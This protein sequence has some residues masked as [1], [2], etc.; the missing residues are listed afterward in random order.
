MV[1]FPS[2][3]VLL[4]AATF[5][6]AGLSPAPATPRA[7]QAAGTVVFLGDSLTAGYGLD[8][9]MAFPALVQKEIDERNWPWRVV[10]AGVSGETSAGGLRRID[11]LL[12][13]RIDVLVL[14]LGGN[15]GLR[16]IP[17]ESTRSNLQ[18]IIDRTRSR[19]PNVR[20]VI[21]GM[22][23]PPNL[24][25]TYTSAFRD[26]YPQLARDNDAVLVPFLLEG[27]GGDPDL[28]LPDGIHPT[29]EGHRIVAANVWAI[30]EPLLRPTA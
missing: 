11:W 13:S 15:D 8:P 19:Y 24:G 1:S 30:L 9:A 25:E 23:M 7:L 26:L 5:V 12:R 14:E 18:A 3:T 17:P 10:N 2:R 16:G 21:A 27:V 22:Q 28:N 6:A 29:A 20:L 4:V